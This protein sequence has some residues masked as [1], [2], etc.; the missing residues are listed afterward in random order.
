MKQ[1]YFLSQRLGFTNAQAD[2]IRQMGIEKF[3]KNAFNTSAQVETPAFLENAPKSR[4]EY[5]QLRQSSDTQKK[6]FVASE[7]LRNLG[8]VH[9][10]QHKMYT[11]TYPLREKMVLFWHNH[12]VSSFQKVKS[13]WTM[14]RQ[15]QLF[16]EH[17]FGNF[18]ELTRLVLY[19]NAMLIYLD[20]TQN[21]A[22]NP[23]ENLSRELLE[24]FTLGVGNYSEQDIKEGAKALAGLNLAEDGARYYPRMSDNSTKTYLGKKGNWQ[25]DDLVK[26]IFEHPKAAYRISE[27]LLKHFVTDTP[28]VEMVSEYAVF[29]KNKDFEI[30]PFIEKM[31][32]DPRFLNSQG[33]KIKDPLSFIMQLHYE[34]KL[35]LA[36]ARYLVPYF[37]GQGMTLLNP[38][39]VK[40]WD[41]GKSWLSSQKL[42][43][44]LNA[45]S[46]ISSGKN[47]EIG[48]FKGQKKQDEALEMMQTDE[49][50]IFGE[51]KANQTPQFRWDNT[52]KNNKDI[53]KNMTDRLVFS[54]SKDM[55]ADMEQ[56]LKYDFNPSQPNAQQAI[57]RLA[58][59]VMKTPE[60]QVY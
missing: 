30:K 32:S 28:S 55:Q 54:V 60:F 24:L 29:F 35:D 46:L 39:N 48:R 27:K 37:Q 1:E 52:L 53:I 21:K 18:R 56:I 6:V 51:S 57:T 34:F 49:T 41:G 14:Y 33:A 45:V 42:L 7:A 13:A 36:Q 38:P 58:E 19:D 12:F 50:A 17:A 47:M 3:I 43:Q 20:N 40:G 59:Y 31:V 10:W 8:I 16:R 26:I 44:R 23:N 11:D 22:N 25:A 9:W 5:R 15:N 4:K 2:A